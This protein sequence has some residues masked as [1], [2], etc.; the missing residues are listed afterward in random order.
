M[1]KHTT[2][3]LLI[4]V[5]TGAST[6]ALASDYAQLSFLTGCWASTENGVTTQENWGDMRGQTMLGTSK[7]SKGDKTSAFE[8][9][10]IVKTDTG[11]R[12]IPYINGKQASIFQLTGS[13]HA[14][15]TFENKQND[16][17]QVI[18]YAALEGALQITLSGPGKEFSY[19]LQ[20][21]SCTP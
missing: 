20:S 12:Y 7:T 15:A 9:L 17:P 10:R 5:L 6:N 13:S 21:A 14:T 16:F 19:S 4:A 2:Y 18:T 11:A 8:F 3:A 1:Q